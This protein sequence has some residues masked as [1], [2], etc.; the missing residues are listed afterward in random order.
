MRYEVGTWNMEEKILSLSV[1]RCWWHSNQISNDDN[2]EFSNN[3]RLLW[4]NIPMWKNSERILSTIIWIQWQGRLS[5]WWVG[6]FG[7]WRLLRYLFW[8]FPYNVHSPCC[9][10]DLIFPNGYLFYLPTPSHINRITAVSIWIQSSSV[11]RLGHSERVRARVRARKKK[12][13]S[14]R[15]KAQEKSASMLVTMMC[16]S[17]RESPSHHLC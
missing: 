10:F 15:R 2:N 13:N 7:V 4:V 1:F 8:S 12:C 3:F 16:C 14:V 6:M 5:Q 17:R 11:R 9:T